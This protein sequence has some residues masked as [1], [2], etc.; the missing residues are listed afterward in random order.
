MGP[1]DYESSAELRAVERPDRGRIEWLDR[2]DVR[3]VDLD[4]DVRICERD[5]GAEVEVYDDADPA[6]KP[7]VSGRPGLETAR[8]RE[9]WHRGRPVPQDRGLARAGWC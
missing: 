9:A 4:C 5:V 7:P 2:V 8:D 1:D 3:G 6:S